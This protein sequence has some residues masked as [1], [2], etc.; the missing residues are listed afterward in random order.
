MACSLV[1]NIV[2]SVSEMVVQESEVSRQR[3]ITRRL[4]LSVVLLASVR[5]LRRKL[6]SLLC[7]LQVPELLTKVSPTPVIYFCQAELG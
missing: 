6:I 3:S 4:S 2:Q 7:R 5:K 1:G